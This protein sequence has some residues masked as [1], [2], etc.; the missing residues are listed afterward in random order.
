MITTPT[1]N[2]RRFRFSLR[3]LLLVL[4][5]VGCAAGW[6][7]HG[8]LKANERIRFSEQHG[9]MFQMPGD[10]SNLPWSWKLFIDM[11]IA[12]VWVSAGLFTEKDLERVQALFPEAEVILVP[13]NDDMWRRERE[14]EL[15]SSHPAKC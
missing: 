6:V 9:T 11:P 1:I 15:R 8:K 14:I 13:A 4:T 5:L 7:A 2:R 12:T 10:P 3:T